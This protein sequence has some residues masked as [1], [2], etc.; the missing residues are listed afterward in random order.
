MRLSPDSIAR[1][2]RS[3]MEETRAHQDTFHKLSPKHLNRYLQEFA[4]KHNIRDMD[5]AAQMTAVTAGLVGKRLMYRD[6][7]AANG[8]SSG[9]WSQWSDFS[10][11]IAPQD[12]CSWRAR[13]TPNTSAKRFGSLLSMTLCFSMRS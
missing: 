11:H 2:I 6:L 12:R 1:R 8:L 5:T 13:K 3:R 4:G 9:A 10:V 7:I